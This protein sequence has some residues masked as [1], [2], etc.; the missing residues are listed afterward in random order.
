MMKKQIPA[1]KRPV[2]HQEQT[3]TQTPDPAIRRQDLT[4]IPADP[5]HR[6]AVRLDQ[7]AAVQAS[8]TQ[9]ITKTI[10]QA[11]VNTMLRLPTITL[12]NPQRS[13]QK[14]HQCLEHQMMSSSI[15]STISCLD[16]KVWGQNL[17]QGILDQVGEMWGN[18]F[19]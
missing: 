5:D 2:H 8:P 3:I 12:A 14:I 10:S 6:L 9:L 11:M 19:I 15:G 4:I 13:Q 17:P 16:G 18:S 7:P 1:S